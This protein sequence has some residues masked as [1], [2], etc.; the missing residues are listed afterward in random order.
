MRAGHRLRQR[1]TLLG[2]VILAFQVAQELLVGLV[3]LQLLFIV[4]HP[5]ILYLP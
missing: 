3:A 2:H 1:L 5:A 4:F